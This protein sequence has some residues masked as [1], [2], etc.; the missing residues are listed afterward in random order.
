MGVVTNNCTEAQ[1]YRLGVRV[2]FTV[3]RVR[4]RIKVRVCVGFRLYLTNCK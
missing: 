3:I 4:V 1:Q 2:S